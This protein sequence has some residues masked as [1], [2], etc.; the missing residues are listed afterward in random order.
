MSYRWFFHLDA[1]GKEWGPFTHG[2]ISDLLS[3]TVLN[4][5]S[6]IRPAAELKWYSYRECPRRSPGKDWWQ[7]YAEPDLTGYERQESD[8]LALTLEK[9]VA[10]QRVQAIAPNPPTP[11]KLTF[12]PRFPEEELA[13][14]Y[15]G[16]EAYGEA[17]QGVRLDYKTCNSSVASLFVYEAPPEILGWDTHDSEM[18]AEFTKA[19][20]E[21]KKM[22]DSGIYLH[23][24]FSS[25]GRLETETPEGLCAH[26]FLQFHHID[27]RRDTITEYL[28]LTLAGGSFLKVRYTHPK[29]LLVWEFPRFL[30]FLTAATLAADTR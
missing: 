19:V 12:D 5:Q 7:T 26:G 10:I 14:F 11:P 27:K 4:Q 6:L 20:L 30:K 9:H 17:S 1:D 21:Y 23:A 16:Y 24:E 18:L 3:K 22:A 25:V 2:N 15:S 28:T 8:A 13:L 29:Y